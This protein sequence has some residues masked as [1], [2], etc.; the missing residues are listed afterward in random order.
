MRIFPLYQESVCADGKCILPE[1][2]KSQQC[3]KCN[4]AHSAANCALLRIQTV[5][6]HTLVTC[7]MQLRITVTVVGLLKNSDIIRAAFMQIS[8]FIRVHRIDFDADIFEVF[9][10]DFAG[11]ADIFH[12][13]HIPAFTCQDQHFFHP[14]PGNRFH[15]SAYAIL[16]K[17]R[18]ANLILAVETAVN[19]VI[20]T[21]V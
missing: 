7:K 16:I 12:I 1:I 15:F 11:T 19:T 9:M 5:R 6:E 14:R 2:G 13:A 4:A 8:I 21:V 3:R 10:C 20:F 17:L 18:T